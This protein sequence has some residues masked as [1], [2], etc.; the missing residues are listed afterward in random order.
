MLLVTEEGS[1]TSCGKD[2]IVVQW[3]GAGKDGQISLREELDKRLLQIR[4]EHMRWAY[5]CGVEKDAISAPSL[6]D[7]FDCGAKPSMWWTSILYE[8]HPKVSPE[9]Y[10]L[11]K[12]RC[13]EMLLAEK[14]ICALELGGGD[15]KLKKTLK[16]LC[17][18]K[19]IAF[20]AR[21]GKQRQKES[22]W[23][24]RLYWRLPAPL[25][26]VARYTHWYI[27]VRRLL[28]FAR[29][30]RDEDEKGKEK[31][32]I[33]S[34]FPNIDLRE[35]A[36]GRFRSRYWEKLH[37]LLNEA[38]ERENPAGSHF[39]H[40]LFIR[41]PSPELSLRQGLELCRTF[42]SKGKDG[43]SF[44][45]LE[46][47]LDFKDLCKSLGRW[48][49]LCGKS[50]LEQG[51]FAGKCHFKDSSLNFWPYV[52]EQWAESMR[53]WRCLERC[54]QNSAFKHYFR[55]APSWRWI[56][57]PLE[58]CP[59]ERMLTQAAR[60]NDS[61]NPVYGAQHSIIRPTDF[62][63]FDDPR[64]FSDP[65]CS[66]FQPAIFGANGQ[67]GL[68][69]WA[70]NAMPSQRRMI[71]EALRYQYLAEEA[72][73]ARTLASD[74]GSPGEPLE[75]PGQRLLLLTS[76]F[77]DE[78]NAHLALLRVALEAK[79]LEGWRVLIKPHPYLEVES[80]RDS[81]PKELASQV[82]IIG[83]P[84]S[85][86]LAEGG[87]IWTSNST[88]AALEAALRA[89]PVM[90]MSPVG[91]FD[92]CPIQN[93]PNLARTATLEDVKRYLSE[94]PVPELPRNYLDLSPGLEKWRKLLELP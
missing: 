35:A 49:A 30:E 43:A 9:L 3:E 55:L 90:V 67:S 11:Y 76:F 79:A 4:G 57:F 22:S 82:E 81:L 51:S 16:A 61:D 45:Y 86:A 1:A 60:E 56:L 13:L 44:H 21:G 78:T 58:N 8:R 10:P 2:L 14:E 25:R 38:A 7:K 77:K 59:W 92:L 66:S 32:L 71:L 63:Y 70:E 26:A 53:G 17:R 5:E 39:V 68:A 54:L 88:T 37:N 72:P 42:A 73:E 87:L 85:L 34:Y 84:L 75:L 91:D 12:L 48:L 94:M 6:A 36:S 74:P 80:W 46:Q 50:I 93:V 41:F 89:L 23:L 15:R 69:Q 31:A 40:W 83:T 18:A 19:G 24:K 29:Q 28:P 62:R 20:S 52:K 47:F 65:E 33:V 64:T 27:T